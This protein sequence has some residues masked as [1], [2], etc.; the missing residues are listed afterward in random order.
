[1]SGLKSVM[2]S[3]W[4]PEKKESWRGDNKGINQVAGWV[5]KGKGSS[6]GHT[7]DH[8]SAP[9]STLRDPST[10]APPPKH[11]DYYGDAATT[12]S[13]S[14]IGEGSSAS[15]PNS[16]TGTSHV[17][18]SITGGELAQK[19]GQP[20]V[21]YRSNSIGPS[22]ELLPKPPV[23]RLGTVDDAG[24]MSPTSKGPKPALPPR[25]P[26]RQ[27]VVPGRS[28]PSSTSAKDSGKSYLNQG[29]LNRLGQSGVSV[30]GFNIGQH[31]TE[32]PAASPTQTQKATAS[33]AH[34][35]SYGNGLQSRL[36]KVS[37]SSQ[38]SSAPDTGTSLE[39]KQ[40]ALRTAYSFKND[41]GSISMNDARTAATTANNF[42]ERHGD[43]VAQGWNSA[44]KLNNKYGIAQKVQQQTS[45]VNQT[46]VAEQSTTHDAATV[47]KKP[48]P[49]PPK[50]KELTQLS[51]A[52][53]T[54]PPVPVSSKPK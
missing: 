16:Q 44:N 14:P 48:P 3:G 42:K 46:P 37:L 21:P 19:Q 45:S 53:V 6:S 31:H 17:P 50:K 40:A 2:K 1:M 23:K 5:G 18:T 13:K 36:A 51:S 28:N 4:H 15:H 47:V 43:Q 22:L 33:T 54:P 30:P 9:L 26:P 24:S 52:G 10:F 11:K 8:Q 12:V 29:A 38:S 34:V 7:Q 32:S 49:P 35:P 41:P 20:S 39:Q 25:L 27:G